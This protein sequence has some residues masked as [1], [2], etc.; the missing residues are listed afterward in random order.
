MI[1][2]SDVE[3]PIQEIPSLVKALGDLY[4]AQLADEANAITV[5]DGYMSYGECEQL[6]SGLFAD[7]KLSYH[8]G[9]LWGAMCR[10]VKH[11]TLHFDTKCTICS[12]GMEQKIQVNGRIC[13][14]VSGVTGYRMVLISKMSIQSNL[15]QMTTARY[16]QVGE[17]IKSDYLF[18]ANTLSK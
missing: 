14:H 17:S 6:L 5:P 13:L 8:A 7:K 15:T 2:G 12:G 3:V 9:R 4:R 11:D 10:L 18:I 16:H 1:N